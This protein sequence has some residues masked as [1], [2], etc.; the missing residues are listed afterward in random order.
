[1]LVVMD[2]G[3]GRAR[4]ER[5]VKRL[6]KAGFSV[7]R[8]TL[9]G[10]LAAV[11]TEGE[12]KGFDIRDLRAM[13]GVREVVLYGEPFPLSG[14]G[15]GSRTS[16]LRAG[17]VEIGGKE[18]TLIAGPCAVESE[19]QIFATAREVAAAGARFLRGGAFKPRTS[20][21]SF[22]GLGEDG[23]RLLRAAAD[24][25]GLLAVT[26][27][28]DVSKVGLVEKYADVVQVGARS[29]QNFPLLREVGRL[30]KPVLLKRGSGAT[31]EEMLFSAE[32]VLSGGCKKV[33]LCER[34]IRGFDRAVRHALDFCGLLALRQTTRLPVI[35]DPSHACGVRT[36][37][38]SLAM[39]AIAAGADGVMVEV[40]PRP[41]EALSDAAQS[42][43]FREFRALVEGCRGVAAAA[44]RKWPSS[45]R[46]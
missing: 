9:G 25:C 15:R 24:K 45:R 1:M 39:A 31:I 12:E 16:V 4:V 42:L 14:R 28:L 38:R 21:Y 40:H 13:D 19:R 37:V 20:P 6:E 10:A 43:S 35:V 2:I 36:H 46:K 22:Q 23:L 7:R 18:I 26:E 41:D 34:G 8:H 11:I 30:E 29:M 44:G 3:A 32:Y 33:I 27:V 5:V 17:K